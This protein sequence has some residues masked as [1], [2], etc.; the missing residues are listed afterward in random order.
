M[1]L[2]FPQFLIEIKYKIALYGQKCDFSQSNYLRYPKSPVSFHLECYRL[3]QLDILNKN[4][5]NQDTNTFPNVIR[6]FCSFPPSMLSS[7]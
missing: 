5:R 7:M 1:S 4:Y 3:S 2:A 6:Y